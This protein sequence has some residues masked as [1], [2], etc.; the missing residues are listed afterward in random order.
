MKLA[1]FGATGRTGQ[2]LVRLALAEN[3]MIT[4]LARDPR[5]LPLSNNNLVC[6]M[7]DAR[8]SISVDR[9]ISGADAVISVLGPTDRREPGALTRCTRN[10]IQAMKQ[11]DLRRLVVSAGAG[12]GDNADSPTLA[13]HLIKW[14]LKTT[15][16][17]AYTDMLGVA[18]LVRKSGLDWTIARAPMLTDQ[19]ATGSIKVGYLGK[20]VGIRLSRAD[21]ASF[22]LIQVVSTEYFY[23]APVVSN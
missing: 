7:G 8:D 6:I 12:I 22:M 9:T 15:A 21:L 20:G 17:P 10:I 13:D 5:K 11:N 16:R 2:H 19:P 23:K 14:L 1:I 18:S 4:A 3:Y